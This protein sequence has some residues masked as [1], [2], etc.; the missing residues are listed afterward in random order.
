MS[1]TLNFSYSYELSPMNRNFDN[2]H[3]FI[4]ISRAAYFY[5]SMII[6]LLSNVMR[7]KYVFININQITSF[8]F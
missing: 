8:R 3:L 2:D 6:Q 7:V 5:M 4:D 1:W